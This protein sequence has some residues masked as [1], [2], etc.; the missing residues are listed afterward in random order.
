MTIDSIQI[1]PV[2]LVVYI[3]CMSVLIFATLFR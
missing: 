1:H 2:S 3:I